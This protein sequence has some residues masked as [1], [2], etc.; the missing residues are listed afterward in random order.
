MATKKAT[1]RPRKKAA[2]SGAEAPKVTNALSATT[3]VPRTAPTRVTWRD[4]LRDR[5]H[6]TRDR[7]LVSRFLQDTLPFAFYLTHTLPEEAVGRGI[8]IKSISTDREFAKRA[9]DLFRRWADSRAVDL[10]KEATLYELQPLWLATILGDGE[11]FVQKMA[12]QMEGAGSWKLQDRN[13]RR[14]QLQSFTRDQ[15][16]NPTSREDQQ[17]NPGRWIDGIR[18]NGL[19][20]NDGYGVITESADGTASGFSV[21]N[22]PLMHHAKKATRLNQVHGNP[23]MFCGASDLLDSLDIT[24]VRKHAAKIKSAFM[25]A[26]VTRDGDIPKSM[27]SMITRGDTGTTPADNGKRYAEIFGGAIVLPMAADEDI[28][29]F[30]AHEAM[31]YGRFIEEIVSPMV[32]VFGYPPEYVFQKNLTGPNQRAILSK[33]AKAHERMRSLLYPVLQ[34]VWDWV[35]GDALVSGE[36]RDIKNPPLDWN[37]VDFVADPD[38][39]IDLGRD[40]RIEIERLR[41]NAG[42]MEDY[43]ERRTGG[44]GEAVRH[45]RIAEKLDDIRY[46][47]SE[48]KRLGIPAGLAM[49]RAMDP[50]ELQAMAGALNVIG[51][52][53]AEL[54]QAIRAEE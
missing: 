47:V 37:Q 12:A 33:V 31:D 23:W 49:V 13:K 22:G 40:E 32:W 52:D 4:K 53:A 26:T 29:W 36:L 6:E 19:F 35:I 30:Q 20:Q 27:Q 50:V 51:V 1:K 34:W 43:I 48:A 3:G 11:T 54:A 7:V 46:A 24:A 38:P 9:T 14:L 8:G 2:V 15:L 25:G 39:S 10:R 18:V 28:K 41:G 21:V 17:A 42:T 5:I 45:A 16:T 44:S